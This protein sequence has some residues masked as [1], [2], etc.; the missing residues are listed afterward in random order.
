MVPH[1]GIEECLELFEV[2]KK[3]MTLLVYN[4]EQW[5]VVL[6]AGNSEFAKVDIKRGIFQGYPLSPLVFVLA[7]AGQ[8]SIRVFR[9]QRKHESPFIYGRFEVTQ[10]QRERIGLV[11]SDNT[12]FY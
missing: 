6:Y 2:A 11:S 9:K 1:S 8:G 12:H 5:R 4:M 10:S 3:I 7:K